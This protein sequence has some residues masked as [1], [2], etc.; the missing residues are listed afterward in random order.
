MRFRWDMVKFPE[1]TVG[2]KLLEV[3]GSGYG[4]NPVGILLPNSGVLSGRFLRNPFSIRLEFTGI[5]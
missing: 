1:V 2:G 4:K 5:Y 3:D